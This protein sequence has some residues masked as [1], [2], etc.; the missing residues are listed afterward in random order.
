VN[1]DAL[2]ESV[3]GKGL[4]W[5]GC[6]TATAGDVARSCLPTGYE[7]LDACLPGGGWPA[8]TLIELLF[9]RHGIGELTLLLPVL[10]RLCSAVEHDPPRWL[11]WLSPPFDPY[12]PALA[13]AGVDPERVLLVSP[14]SP[15]ETLWAAE[16]TLRSGNCGAVL[17]WVEPN[18]VERHRGRTADDR[19]LR[20]LKLAAEQGAC[21][22][23]LFRPA[24]LRTQSSPASLRLLLTPGQTPGA[25]DVEVLKSRGG[26]PAQVRDVFRRD[27]SR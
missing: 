21:L 23:V 1:V 19:W 15:E 24:R 20:R 6:A 3:A 12:V 2:L 27:D 17:A 4:L 18:R 7:R 13:Q 11:V 16:Q 8:A 22:G 5:R 25:L 10:A 26:A 14:A 9:V